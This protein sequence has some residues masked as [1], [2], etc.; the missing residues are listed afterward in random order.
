MSDGRTETLRARRDEHLASDR[1]LNNPGQVSNKG[2]HGEPEM[3]D[4][5]AR[6]P[7]FVAFGHVT[8][9]VR[10]PPG[11]ADDRPEPGGTAA[12]A[13]ETAHAM[14]LAAGIV[15]SSSPGYPFDTLLPSTDVVNVPAAA[16][17]TFEFSLHNGVRTQ[18][19][20]ARAAEITRSHVPGSWFGAQ[21]VLLGPV[22]YELPRHAADWFSDDSFVCA[23]LQGWQRSRDVSGKVVVSPAVPSGLSRRIDAAVISEADVPAEHVDAWAQTFCIVAVTRGRRGA[24]VFVNGQSRD[25]PPVAASEVDA[26]GAGDVWAAAFAINLAETRDVA[27]AANFASAAAAI[28]IERRGMQ[29]IPTRNAVTARMRTSQ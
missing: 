9:D 23:V 22:A 6:C 25:I 12:F 20:R 18:W 28:S 27:F 16:T 15:T 8:F 3:H 2:P 10:L 21:V 1:S 24:R 11:G 17:T 26:T 29:G 7:E 4:G 13:A 19:L 5:A 14:G